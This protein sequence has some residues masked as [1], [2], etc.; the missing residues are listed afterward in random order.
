ML[1]YLAKRGNYK[2]MLYHYK[3]KKLLSHDQFVASIREALTAAVVDCKS[4]SGHSFRIGAATAA[5]KCGL[6][7]ATIQTLGRWESS[8]YLPYIRMSRVEL[9]GVSKLISSLK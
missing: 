8:A 4:Y 5:G 6:P 1:A 7:P 9:V 3:D 2:G